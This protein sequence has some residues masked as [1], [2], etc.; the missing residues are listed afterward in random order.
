[1]CSCDQSL[2]T[3]A[4][5][6]KKLSQPQFYN[7][8][9]RK[10]T[11]FEGWSWLKFNNVELAL[12]RNLKFYTNM[13]KGLKWK[14]R[15]FLGTIP[16][17]AEVTGETPPPPLSWI[18]LNSRKVTFCFIIMENTFNTRQNQHN[19]RNSQLTITQS[20]GYSKKSLYTKF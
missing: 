2:V 16:T 14:V 11:F 17:F 3:L 18:G 10:I 13:A 5:L 20:E 1:M 12:G 9:T 6:W 7:D 8:S 19:F 4:F 15:K